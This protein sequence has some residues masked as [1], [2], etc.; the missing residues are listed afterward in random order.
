MTV[1]RKAQGAKR[2]VRASSTQPGDEI[3]YD[4]VQPVCIIKIIKIVIIRSKVWILYVN[5]T[6]KSRFWNLGAAVSLWAF[7]D[8]SGGDGGNGRAVVSIVEAVPQC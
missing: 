1:G 5:F 6:R 2:G 4:K 7:G 3:L 8:G